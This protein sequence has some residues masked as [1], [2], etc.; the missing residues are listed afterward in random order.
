MGNHPYTKSKIFKYR[1]QHQGNING[2]TGIQ[3]SQLGNCTYQDARERILPQLQQRGNM[4]QVS[5][6]NAHAV[7]FIQELSD[8]GF[9]T[10]Q[11]GKSDWLVKGTKLLCSP[12]RKNTVK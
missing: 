11:S 9:C 7:K 2:A 3:D 6:K 1:R 5:K 8:A 12:H 10:I 4:V